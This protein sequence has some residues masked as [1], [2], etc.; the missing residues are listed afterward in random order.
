MHPAPRG[1]ARAPLRRVGPGMQP[2]PRI[3]G[4][5]TDKP[6]PTGRQPWHSAEAWGRVNK[7]MTTEQVTAILGEPTTVESISGFK[8]LFYRGSTITGVA[9]NGLVNLRDER[10]VAVNVPKF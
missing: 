4:M 3:G 1:R 7:G 5:R 2:K 6:A 10:V 8:T 9:L